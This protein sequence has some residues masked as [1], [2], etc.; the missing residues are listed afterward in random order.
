MSKK[1][2]DLHVKLD[3]QHNERLAQAE[4]HHKEATELAKTQHDE[5]LSRIAAV[6]KPVKKAPAKKIVSYKAKKASTR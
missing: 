1:F 3:A 6:A 4:R 2:D 5:H